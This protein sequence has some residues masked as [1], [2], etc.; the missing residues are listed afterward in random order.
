MNS[1]PPA[2]LVT[3]RGTG[4]YARNSRGRRRRG[5]LST[6]SHD[7][8]LPD[9]EL[10]RSFRFSK[11]N[12]NPITVLSDEDFNDAYLKRLQSTVS[13]VSHVARDK[14][15]TRN[16][17]PVDILK[18]FWTREMFTLLA[19]GFQLAESGLSAE[20]TPSVWA[21]FLAVILKG[22]F[23]TCASY[24]E[25][26]A[27]DRE[28][29]NTSC[30][31]DEAT[32]MKVKRG[33][34]P[35]P[36]P[37]DDQGILH[38][39]YDLEAGVDRTGDIEP[40]EL[41]VSRRAMPFVPEGGMVMMDDDH[42]QTQ[43]DVGAVCTQKNP[44][45]DRCG[46]FIDAACLADVHLLVATSC[47]QRKESALVSSARRI[48]RQMRDHGKPPSVVFFDRDYSSTL[49]VITAMHDEGL[50][51]FGTVGCKN[52]ARIRKG[53]QA[54]R[55]RAKPYVDV[56]SRYMAQIESGR[57]SDLNL[58][59]LI[60]LRFINYLTYNAYV[61]SRCVATADMLDSN[62]VQESSVDTFNRAWKSVPFR[63]FI[64][65]INKH[66]A[67]E[68]SA[69][70]IPDSTRSEQANL[71]DVGDEEPQDTPILERKKWPKRHRLKHADQE[72]WRSQRLNKSL[73]H[74]MRYGKKKR[75]CV[76]CTEYGD[77]KPIQKRKFSSYVCSG[78]DNLT[79]CVRPPH[80]GRGKSCW[81][82]WHSVVRLGS[83][84]PSQ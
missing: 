10:Q 43:A 38:Q 58:S 48:V 60:P 6:T 73:P 36:A 32:F 81:D 28:Y 39:D 62:E 4:H 13:H 1:A 40:W 15:P 57:R 12:P 63:V 37:E 20:P 66:I 82:R 25:L 2:A 76:A 49:P 67:E 17:T 23:F 74:E 42:L 65:A 26:Y 64:A 55:P 7:R 77:E 16:L 61:V 3:T 34:S 44:Q 83:R 14:L 51:V 79:L 56:L 29:G 47:R 53:L 80:D 75:A 8:N 11:G 22:C 19:D 59:Q 50:S 70:L 18:L 24:R 45:K 69:V 54:L 41:L 71:H 33:L 35:S 68:G 30:L 78:C 52:G 84:L 9:P 72:P 21:S 46:P 5:G 27:M 31:L